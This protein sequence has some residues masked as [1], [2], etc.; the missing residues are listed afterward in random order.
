M[1]I[2][3]KVLRELEKHPRRLRELK[4]KLGNDKKV[5]HALFLLQQQGKVSQKEGTYFLAKGGAAQ[6]AI[7]CNIV[8]VAATFGFASRIDGKGDIF[9]PGR[10]LMGAMPGDQVLVELFARP[11]VPGS[12]EGEVVS[13]TVP[14]K[15]F[16]G[17]VRSDGGRLYLEPDQCAGLYLAIDKSASGG[18]KAGE[19]AAVEILERGSCHAD[20]LVGVSMRFGSAQQ[21]R[22]C[23]KALLYAH[24]MTRHFPDRVKAEASEYENAVPDAGEVACRTDL[25]TWPIFTMDAASTKDI[26]DAVSLRRTEEG[27]ELGVHIADVSC[28]VQPGTELDKEAF[29]RSTSVYYADSVVPMLPR[30]LS[31]GICSLNE[32]ED[33]L[34]FSCLMQLDQMG[35]LVDHKFVKTVIRSRVKGVYSEINALL[36]GSTDPEL[37]EKYAEAREQ[38]PLMHELYEKRLALRKARGGLD[39]ESGESKLI[40]DEDGCCVDVQKA[41][42]GESEAIIEEMMLLANQSAAKTARLAELPFV[43]RVHEAPDAERIDRLKTVLNACHVPVRFNAESPSP[44]HLAEILDSTRGTPVERAVHTGVLR[45]MTKARYEAKPLGHYGLVLEDYAHFTSPIRRYSDLA[46]HRILSAY[47][48]G[49]P[50]PVIQSR[51]A[52]YAVQAAQQSSSQE[53]AA[54]QVE[55]GAEDCYKA[56][57]LNGH[58]GECF[59]GVVSG[60]TAHGIYVEL[61]NTVEGLVHVSQLCNDQPVLTDGVRLTDPRSGK[62]WS[63]GD[64]VRVQ[65]ARTDVALGRVDFALA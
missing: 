49:E 65:V 37:M 60:V 15:S 29:R 43:Y 6:K 13:V 14:T 58:L 31:N 48:E 50:V 23:A 39:I 59:D 41:E 38:L 56:E 21:A 52:D 20:H 42:R 53:L 35:R 4:D 62:S 26:D 51:Y 61:E 12:Q 18:V 47:V 36:A 5:I 28:Y 32:G 40:L 44:V 27:Y 16:V 3:S 7:P 8:K 22:Q 63:L 64:E 1:S 45:S 46:V 11:R 17:T 9:V 54:L 10:S 30:Q 19:K 57:Y 25:R 55:R 33:R 34:A 24:G 2:R